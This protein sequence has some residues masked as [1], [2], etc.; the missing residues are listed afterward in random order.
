MKIL[1]ALKHVPD[2]ET[3]VRV[4]GDGISLDESGVK[5]IVS[6]YDEFA[7]EEALR[8]REAR[9]GEV[10]VVTCGREAS[11]EALKEGL[12]LGADRAVLIRDDRLDR[13]DAL[14]RARALAAVARAESPDLILTGKY[15]VGTD[16][17][18]TG[19]MMAEILDL[20]HVGAASKLKINDGVFVAH[21]EIEGAVEVME[22][23]LP[24]LIS[25]DKGLNEPRYKSLKGIMAAK[26]KTV[27]LR[28]L[29]ELS[30]DAADVE[31]GARV[32][33]ES[34]ELPPPRQAGRKIPGNAAEAARALATLLRDEAKVI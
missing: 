9:G 15:G 18:L 1:V 30:V 25:C 2:T 23:S 33:W 13:S 19:P 6:P 27:E 7:L 29:A 28:T 32:A 10:L 24:A 26:K 20:P 12:A 17:G 5:F 22:G 16:E 34:L 14:A 8:I 31:P 4:A 11:Q 3:K 21:R